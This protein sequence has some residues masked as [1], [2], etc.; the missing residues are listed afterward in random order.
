MTLAAQGGQEAIANYL[1]DAG[2][3]LPA[4]AVGR[5]AS[6]MASTRGLQRLVR[7]LAVDYATL[8]YRGLQRQHQALLIIDE[9]DELTSTNENTSCFSEE[10][11]GLEY[12]RGF[13]R[14][15]QVVQ[16]LRSTNLAQVVLCKSK[17]TSVF[18]RA[19]CYTS[20]AAGIRNEIT[21]L[22]KLRHENIVQL[23]DVVVEDD[24]KQLYVVT[25]LVGEGDLFDLLS[26]KG[27]E[28]TGPEIRIIF[29]QLFSALNFLV[30]SNH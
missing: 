16:S 10:L 14:R 6:V 27:R 28:L 23:V 8:A 5:R 12:S 3:I 4:N 11:E 30:S 9:L 1:A 29:A 20:R 7:R 24:M 13:Q 19:K 21:A 25:E 26:E 2:A 17:A 22:T 18:H 15:Y